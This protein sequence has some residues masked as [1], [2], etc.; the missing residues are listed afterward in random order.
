M[1]VDSICL[2]DGFHS[3]PVHFAPEFH[4]QNIHEDLFKLCVRTGCHVHS[5]S[6]KFSWGL[7]RG[8][9]NATFAPSRVEMHRWAQMRAKT[10]HFPGRRSSALKDPTGVF[11]R[12]CG[13]YLQ[14]ASSLMSS[15]SSDGV[16]LYYDWCRAGLPR[17]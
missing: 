10:V 3:I 4:H 9:V 5:R 1:I 11:Q 13:G 6:L 2:D 14:K 12:I 16:F 15:Q 8:I 17:G 7:R